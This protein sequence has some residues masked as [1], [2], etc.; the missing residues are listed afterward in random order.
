MF[1]ARG[2]RQGYINVNLRNG[3]SDCLY[4][5]LMTIQSGKGDWC[6]MKN[7]SKRIL[8]L[9]FTLTL[10]LLVA[11]YLSSCSDLSLG[12]STAHVSENGQNET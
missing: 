1:V 4:I 7:I 10:L 5:F 6:K 8:V 12:Q 3:K 9:L 11:T 2:R